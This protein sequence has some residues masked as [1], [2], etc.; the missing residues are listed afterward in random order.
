MTVSMEAVCVAKSRPRK[1]Q[2]ERSD[3]PQ[4]YLAIYT[5]IYKYVSWVQAL[6]VNQIVRFPR[7]V[8]L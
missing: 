8:L 4:E 6:W 7:Y 5:N 3:L 2:L 1:N